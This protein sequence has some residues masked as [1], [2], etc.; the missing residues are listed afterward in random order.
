MKLHLLVV[1]FCLFSFIACDIQENPLSSPTEY[2]ERGVQCFNDGSYRQAK[3][4]FEKTL[5]LANQ[6]N[7]FISAA[8]LYGYLGRTNLKLGEYREALDNLENAVQASAQI[9]DYRLQAQACVWKGDVLLQM[10]EFADAA[11]CFRKSMQLSSAL[12]DGITRAQTEVRLGSTLCS[13]EKLE[14]AAVS[15]NEALGSLRNGSPGTDVAEALL[16]LGEVYRRQ[17]KHA[18][19]VNTLT[20]ALGDLGRADSPLLEA[21]LKMTMGL[22]RRAQSNTNAAITEFRDAVNLLRRKQVGRDYETLLLFY[23]GRIY[24]ENGRSGDAKKYYTDA[25]DIAR[26][27]GDKIV[28][29][30]LYVFVVRCNVHLMTQEQREKTIDR[31]L[32]SYQQIARK[33][34][35]CGHRTGEAY[36]YTLIGSIFESENNLAAARTMF[37]KAVAIEAEMR[38]EYVDA[39][40]H[41]PFLA[42]LGIDKE[43][44]DWYEKLAYVLISMNLKNEALATLDLMQLRSS[45]RI[46][47]HLDVTVR[48]PSLKEDVRTCRS[49]LHAIKVMELELSN[50]LSGKQKVV[51][52]QTVLGIRAQLTTLTHEVKEKAE[53]IVGVQPN[54]ETLLVPGFK[55]IQD[56]QVMIPQ[57]S[58]VL[59]F[60]PAE[61]ELFLFALSR[62]RLD[63]R[64]VPI[65][66]D[67]LLSLVHQYQQLLQDPAVYA[68]AGGESSMGLMTMFD[69]LSTRLYDCFIR[70][71]DTQLDRSLVIITRDEFRDFPFHAIERQDTRGNVKYLIE[72][73]SVDYLPSLSSLRYKTAGTS[74]IR[75]VNAFGN[76]TGKNWSV[77]YEL[78][79][80]RS[81]FK[82]ASIMIG[83]EATW[84]NLVT[85]RG[86]V[87]QLS[88][89]FLNTRSGYD[90]G[91][92]V[93]S[94]GKTP[95]ETANA[96]FEQLTGQEPYPLVLLSNQDAQGIG[97][98]PQHALLLRLNGTSDVFLNAWFAD[99]KAAKFF[100]EFVYTNLAAGLAPGD[101]Y[102]QALL[103]L[104]GTREVSHPRSWGQFFHFGIG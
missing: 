13:S 102:R 44:N 34:Q 23:I 45:T 35:E 24:E 2:L 56:L 39:E 20:Q 59:Q 1:L 98:T 33:F 10:R 8:E 58:M 26:S 32:Q 89:D 78:R 4:Y 88:T 93:I 66:K 57:G 79:D 81:F 50:L 99:R 96:A 104:I 83:V 40:L 27:L 21:R 9:S 100:S 5:T 92:I 25:L 65:A 69:R 55:K 29:D 95:G 80:I 12:N 71:I 36:L 16:G 73:T 15:Y 97:L 74:F 75:T 68:G 70:P 14:Q 18:E 46:F 7:E 37:Q 6:H 31:L 86:D 53:L 42:E 49:K 51:D 47:E 67:S 38:G 60:L 41:L 54:Y 48:H 62:N 91:E 30:Y 17:G 43:H 87:L 76:P 52:N 64:R 22:V 28:E 11:N 90:L 82:G 103:N 3:E 72:L 101:A 94:N 77:D 63:V 85:S 19:A 84:K 61:R